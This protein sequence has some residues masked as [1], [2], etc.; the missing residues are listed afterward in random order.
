MPFGKAATMTSSSPTTDLPLTL[1]PKVSLP[2]RMPTDWPVDP[3]PTRFTTLGTF[4]ILPLVFVGQVKEAKLSQVLAKAA[5]ERI[6][7]KQAEMAAS[8]VDRRIVIKAP[9][10][11]RHSARHMPFMD[12]GVHE[13]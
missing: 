9:N 2:K 11:V 6:S 3:V 5:P 13:M 10:S 4:T 8:V 12:I 1:M 7:S